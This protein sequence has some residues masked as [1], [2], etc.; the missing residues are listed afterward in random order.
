MK[1]LKLLVLLTSYLASNAL[2]ETTPNSD[3]TEIKLNAYFNF[4]AGFVNQSNLQSSEKNISANRKDFAFY[5]DASLRAQVSKS[6]DMGLTYGAQLV[7]TPTTNTKTS[8]SY[9]GSHVFLESD[10][11]KFEA[12]SPYDVGTK[13]RITGGD[14]MAGGDWDRYVNLEPDNLAINGA[15]PEFVTYTQYFFDDVYKF[16]SE[17]EPLSGTEP[18]RLISYFTPKLSGFQVGIS[19]I[20]DTGNTGAAG[21]NVA[22]SGAVSKVSTVSS[23]YKSVFQLDRTVKDAF[24]AG[25]SYEHNI[26]DGIDVKVAVTG[27]YGKPAKKITETRT[28][29]DGSP[30]QTFNYK[31]A[32][33]KTYNIGA[34]LNYGSFSYAASYGSLGNS[35][36]AKEYHKGGRKTDYYNGAL[37]YSQ[38]PIKTSVA[39]LKTNQ[40]KST[41]DAVTLGSEYKLASGLL[42]S[43]E[44]TYFNAKGRPVFY[45]TAPKKKTKG[46]IVVGGLKLDI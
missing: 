6:N 18:P 22:S 5:S 36:T 34:V 42:S 23:A 31:L 10:L 44:F 3:G 35:L 4:Q 29:N 13:M 40:F 2:A 37:A 16:K 33:L 38:G 1:K 9:T 7:L 26:S 15:S 43:L 32:A 45:D 14:I 24:A 28:P 30:E 12:G 27:E 21:H 8:T 20:P 11:G 41:V 17:V 39:Y 19:Y 46:A 25:L